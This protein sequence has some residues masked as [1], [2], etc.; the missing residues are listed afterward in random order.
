M[1]R[2]KMFKFMLGAI[3][4]GLFA[5]AAEAQVFVHPVSTHHRS[6]KIDIWMDQP[7]GSVYYPGEKI[8]LYLRA[9]QNCYVT[10]YNI[11]SEGYIHRLWPTHTYEDNFIRG[12]RTY[13]IPDRYDRYDLRVS[14]P[15]GIEYIQAVASLYPY[16]V[17]EFYYREPAHYR[18][19]D[20]WDVS[21]GV[22]WGDPYIAINRINNYC[23]PE[24]HWRQQATAVDMA[25][26]YVDQY[27]YYPRTVCN[28]CHWDGYNISFWN[29]FDPYYDP[30]T[31]YVFH[32]D[33]N[34]R[35]DCA[36]SH[37]TY[38]QKYRYKKRTS[39]DRNRL[40]KKPYHDRRYKGPGHSGDRYKKGSGNMDYP[41][42]EDPPAKYIKTKSDRNGYRDKHALAKYSSNEQQITSSDAAN[43]GRFNVRS[44]TSVD[45]RSKS[46]PSKSSRKSYKTKP[47]SSN[48]SDSYKRSEKSKSDNSDYQ[49]KLKSRNDNIK[50]DSKSYNS[51]KSKTSSEKTSSY[52]TKSYQSSYKDETKSKTSTNKAKYI[53]SNVSSKTKS[54]Q[55]K[56]KS[57]SDK[58]KSGKSKSKSLS[59]KKKSD[60]SKSY[61]SKNKSNS[62][63]SSDKSKSSKSKK[64]ESKYESK[65]KKEAKSKSKS[66]QSK[67]KK[68]DKDDK[69]NSKSSKSSNNSKSK[70]PDDRSKKK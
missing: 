34:Y 44:K 7:E 14:G 40:K 27:V 31:N 4:F 68:S 56:A 24:W 41:P 70:K 19:Y 52:S 66:G 50:N 39:H 18:D 60:K 51:Q 11:D 57:S 63:Y 62:K 8:F 29:S 36:P 25:Y 12:H 15:A 21:F 61:S 17:P 26:F 38:G 9:N 59:E 16:D 30:C 53:S 54:Y 37:Y 35:Y 45:K 2:N 28:D 64:P 23:L 13:R 22:V 49:Y 20:E 32:I 48:E 65:G 5:I 42:T 58:N 6:L 3:I 10:I 67:S 33:V 69:D 1:L 55:A 46:E 47:K 43:S